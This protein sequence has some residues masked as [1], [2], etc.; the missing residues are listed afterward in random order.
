MSKTLWIIAAYFLFQAVLG[1][2][3]RQAKKKQQQGRREATGRPEPTVGGPLDSQDT[4]REEPVQRQTP[5]DI[6]TEIR[7]VMGL[8]RAESSVEVIEEV[9]EPPVAS[10]AFA[11]DVEPDDEPSHGG[12]L[13]DRL[14]ARDLEDH[15]V[16]N[17]A[18]R[19][20]Q[21]GLAG[22]FAG[23][24]IGGREGPGSAR[25]RRPL[26]SRGSAYLDLSDIA[27][28]LVTADIL[29]PPKALRDDF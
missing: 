17:L 25:H 23:S 18:R 26:D 13:R 14:M 16:G 7:R 29:G 28:A 9:Y 21:G 12:D 11:L 27:R 8:E 1:A 6:A 5:E 10:S 15:R 2:L 4:P 19:Q 3:S 24:G 22:R 20:L